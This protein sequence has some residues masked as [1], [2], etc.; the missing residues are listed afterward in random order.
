MKEKDVFMLSNVH[1]Q[2]KL[3]I[4]YSAKHELAAVHLIS[5][6]GIISYASIGAVPKHKPKKA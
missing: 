3:Q 1:A 2:P 4:I 6:K 5:A